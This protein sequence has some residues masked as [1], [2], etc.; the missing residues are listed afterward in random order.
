MESL[1]PLNL[2]PGIEK[3]DFSSA[4]LYAFFDDR[5][6]PPVVARRRLELM[7]ADASLAALL[8]VRQGDPLFRFSTTTLD[9]HDRIIEYSIAEYRSDTNAFE[10]DTCV[11]CTSAT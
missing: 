7:K 1:I 3:V 4:S 8:D 2:Y 11:P 10:L 9:A 5:G 6:N